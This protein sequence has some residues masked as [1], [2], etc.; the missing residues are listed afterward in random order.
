M[1]HTTNRLQKHWPKVRVFI[2][3]TWPKMTD[4]E[5]GRIN[6]DFD[7]FAKYYNEYYGD[8]P[9][10]EASA[11]ELLQKFTNHCDVEDPEGL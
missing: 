3:Q 11:R 4:V 6:G 9:R 1:D 2:Q 8:F 7:V 10:G 5:L